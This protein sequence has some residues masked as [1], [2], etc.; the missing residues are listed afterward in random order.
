MS[1]LTQ[2]QIVALGEAIKTKELTAAKKDLPVGVHNV[3]VTVRITAAITKA[4]DAAASTGTVPAPVQLLGP[5]AVTM[6]LKQLGIGPQRLDEALRQICHD[7]LH[8]H[9]CSQLT[10]AEFGSVET[11]A[12]VF[13]VVAIDVAGKLPPLA[14]EVPGKA[15]ATRVTATVT[16]IQPTL[17]AVGE[18][19]PRIAAGT[20]R[21]PRP[22]KK[23]PA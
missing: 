6:L 12:N 15:G 18:K 13:S 9:K 17:P 23:K 11:L 20:E 8:A 14:F 22:R 21:T 2:L 10:D 4:E 5:G 7:T 3:D 1:A 16:V 19:F